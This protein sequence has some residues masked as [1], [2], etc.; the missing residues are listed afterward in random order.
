MTAAD[1][2][3]EAREDAIESAYNAY[4]CERDGDLL[5]GPPRAR[6]TRDVDALIAAV[7]NATAVAVRDQMVEDFGKTAEAIRADERQRVLA[8]VRETVEGLRWAEHH[9]FCPIS[10]GMV[11]C[12]CG[13]PARDAMADQVLATVAPTNAPPGRKET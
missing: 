7:E 11:G 8:E 9:P 3:W 10:R 1:R 4:L 13:K 5:S 2:V 12:D 6:V